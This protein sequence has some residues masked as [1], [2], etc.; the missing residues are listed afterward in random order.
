[1]YSY[2]ETRLGQGRE[3]AKEFLRANLELTLEIENKVR[4]MANLPPGS[5]MPPADILDKALPSSADE[6]SSEELN[7][8]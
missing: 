4:E 8:D 6:E 3:N 1:Y 7:E 2:G 5:Q